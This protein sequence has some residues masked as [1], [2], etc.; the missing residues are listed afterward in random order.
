MPCVV[1]TTPGERLLCVNSKMM[2]TT[3]P[4]S[5]AA[6]P[7]L[8]ILDIRLTPRMLITVT[9]TIRMQPQKTAFC[10]LL[11]KTW[12]PDQI[13]GSTICQAI[14]TAAMVTIEPTIMVHPA[15]HETALEA[16]FFDH[17]YT[18]PAI[19][20]RALSSAN[21]SATAN[22]PASTRIQVQNMSGPPKP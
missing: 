7:T 5:S 9:M 21:T 15:S 3:T 13:G 16:T 18:D 6:T 22:W 10:A 2:I 11:E 20:Y 19:G 17:W 1:S 14:A 12:N 8:L 4:M